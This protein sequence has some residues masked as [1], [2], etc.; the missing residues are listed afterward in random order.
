MD[1]WLEACAEGRDEND[2]ERG[3]RQVLV[4]FCW[5]DRLSHP[6]STLALDWEDW[7]MECIYLHRCGYG[8]RKEKGSSSKGLNSGDVPTICSDYHQETTKCI[9]MSRNPEYR[10]PASNPDIVASRL[11]FFHYIIYYQYR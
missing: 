9:L 11:V 4:G 5:W 7:E 6:N 1:S 8:I 2:E 3:E 10:L